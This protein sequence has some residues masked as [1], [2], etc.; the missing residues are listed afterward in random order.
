MNLIVN[1]ISKTEAEMHK[2]IEQLSI[3]YDDIHLL[4]CAVAMYKCFD[5]R[6]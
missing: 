3:L 1:H 4:C 2:M 5:V 6:T